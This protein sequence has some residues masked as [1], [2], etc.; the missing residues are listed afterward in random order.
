[1]HSSNYLTLDGDV[2]QMRQADIDALSGRISGGLLGRGDKGYD[3]ARKVWNATVDHR[4]AL[5]ARCMNDADVQAAVRFAAAERMR[6][7]VRG[8]GH[9][10]A[11]NAVVEGGLMIDLSG[12]RAVSVDAA[13]RTARVAP[14][15]LL[16]DFDRE[17]QAHGLA[18]PLGINSTTGVAGLTLG[19][20]FGWL[21]RSLG[22]TIDNLLGV[23]IVTADGTLHQVSATSEPEL[24][25]ALRGGGGNFGVV[26]SFEFRLHPVG[27]EVWAGLVV[28]PGAQARQVLRAW[29]DFNATAPEALSVWTVL[30][31]AP[32]LPFIPAEHHGKD[33]VIFPLVCAGDMEAGEKAAAPVAT[34]GTPIGTHLGPTPYAGFQQAFDPLLTPGG[35]NYW[36]SNN[37]ASLSDAAI[38]LMIEAAKTGPGPECEIFVAQLGG[39][40]ARVDPGGH[41]LRRPRRRLHHERA[42]PL[43]RRERGQAGA[44]V[45]AQG[46]HRL[47]AACHR[48]RLRQLPHRGRRRARGRNLRRELRPPAGG[49]AAL[50]PGQPVPR[51]PQHRAAGRRVESRS[52]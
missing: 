3:D 11:G 36:K 38:D 44:R 18:T 27:P 41:R 52:P 9:H 39:A 8:G 49:E 13:K 50:R 23:T 10:I 2:R 31:K 28:Y 24:F 48:R 20:G 6:L 19:G 35:R 46:L 25:W 43:G 32:P 29:R 15:A 1:M 12:W 47:G 40:M 33:V 5:I 22:L 42:R 4:P 21:T 30:R 7:S 34:F 26:T 14:G 37:F 16:S 45:G 51:Q 17:A